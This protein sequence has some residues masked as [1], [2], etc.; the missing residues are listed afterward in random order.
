MLSA[1]GRRVALLKILRDSLKRLG[2]SG[3]VLA[4]DVTKTSPAF[5]LGDDQTLVPPYRQPE[6]LETLLKVCQEHEIK[7]IVPTIDPDL[8]FYAKHAEAFNA[9]GTK[10]VISSDATIAIGR[11]KQRTH[12]WLTQNNLP[13]VKQCSPEHALANPEAWA[14]P[15]FVKPIA[16]SASIGATAVRDE[17][18]LV[19]STRE[20]G[21]I[22]QQ[23]AT[24]DE[25]TVD[26]YIDPQGQC[27]CA[28]PRKRLETRAGEVS[29]G[30]TVRCEPVI[31]LAKQVAAAL[32]GA[33][34]VLNVQIIHNP[35]TDSMNIIEINPRFGGGHP[36]SDAA[37]ATMV[38]WVIQDSLGL[39]NEA[40]EDCWDDGLI[41]LRY[42]DAVFVSKEAAGL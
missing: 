9:I 25:Y 29:K 14:Y 3:K 19:Y 31:E 38:E 28:V 4:T 26:L 40:S 36:L 7:L 24:G 33:Y 11:D 13:T 34:G 17:A 12:D 6:C 15:L 16:G 42:D 30:M 8:P 2:V 10:I 20:G 37:G 39:S 21:Y 32:P 22:V 27:R 41:M 18:E 5:H 1:S 35:D 23:L